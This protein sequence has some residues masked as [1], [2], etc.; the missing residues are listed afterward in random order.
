MNEVVV[1]IAITEEINMV[2]NWKLLRTD[3]YC[4]Q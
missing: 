4:K 1:D 3:F 2:L